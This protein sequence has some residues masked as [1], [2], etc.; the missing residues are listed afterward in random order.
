[1]Q[2][3]HS[4]FQVKAEEAEKIQFFVVDIEKKASLEMDFSLFKRYL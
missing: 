1:M 3:A 4:Y 2:E